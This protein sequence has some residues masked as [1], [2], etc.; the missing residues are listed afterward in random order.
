M[1]SLESSKL[2]RIVA[3]FA[4]MVR[5]VGRQ[6]RLCEADLD[7][8][9]QEVRIRLWRVHSGGSRQGEKIEQVSASYVYRTTMSAAIDILRRRRSRG[10]ERTVA[11]DEVAEP[12]SDA[13]D[14]SRSVEESELAAQLA[15]ALEAVTASRRPAVRM[16]LAG[17]AR[18]E[19]AATMGWSEAKTRNLLYRGLADLR[20]RLAEMGIPWKTTA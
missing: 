18:E 14:P 10:A 19:I 12:A 9:M 3:E 6:F 7:E 15:Q 5:R 8:V 2:E 13:S 4:A 20:E 1:S 11:L 17:Y 16:Y